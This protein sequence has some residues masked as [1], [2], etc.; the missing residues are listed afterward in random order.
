MDTLA[1]FNLFKDF[2]FKELEKAD[3]GE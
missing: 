2:C 3:K 1:E